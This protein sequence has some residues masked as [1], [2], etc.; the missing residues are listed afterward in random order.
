MSV[1]DIQRAVQN[2]TPYSF[3]IDGSVPESFPLLDSILET[4]LAELGQPKIHEALSYCVK[5]LILNAE[6]ANAKRIYFEEHGLEISRKEDYEKGMIGFHRELSENL[7][8]FLQRLRERQMSIDVAFH[9]TGGGLT[10]TV[11][12]DAALAP[13]EQARIKERIVR[14]R[15]FRSF[16][17]AL[18]TSLDH[19]EGAGLGIMI[20][21]QFLKSIGLEEDGFSVRTERGKTV[22]SIVVP[23]AEVQLDQ[24]R[25]LTEVL[26]RNIDSLPHLPENVTK[27]VRLI[28]DENARVADI[29][30]YI[31]KDP[32]LTAELL[33]HVNSAYYGLPARVNGI[34]QAVKLIGLRSLHQLLY[35]FGFHIILDQHHPQMKSLWEHSL[36]TAFYAYLLARD[37]KRQPEILDDVYVAGI[38]HDIGFIAVT[39]LNPKIRDK[40]RR[41]CVEKNIPLWVLERF[42]FGMRHADIGALIAQKWN[43]PDQLVEGIKYHHDPLQASGKHRNIAFCVYL[44]NAVC[45]LEKGLISYRQIDQSVLGDFGLRNEGQFL[46]LV[47]NLESGFDNRQAGLDSR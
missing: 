7:T 9:S 10:V 30:N 1:A 42:S 8:H 23:I 18:E 12:N 11:T 24:I 26:V 20:L 2:S 33:K 32:T 22:S 14:A 21:L 27:L 17:E 46:D 6:K 37:V 43:F 39:T 45:D 4:F 47:S 34:S 3:R 16:S 41:F 28:E 31:S 19:S 5:E 36:R 13:T 40:M 25:S 15:T 38:L 29:S 35:S 44:A